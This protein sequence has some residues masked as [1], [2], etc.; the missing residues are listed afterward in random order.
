[1]T[2]P[3][4]LTGTATSMRACLDK[5]HRLDAARTPYGDRKTEKRPTGISRGPLFRVS[6]TSFCLMLHAAH[7]QGGLDAHPGMIREQQ[8]RVRQLALEALQPVL[9]RQFPHKAGDGAAL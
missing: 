3:A 1:M 2:Q 8:Q 6:W 4:P 7:A 5:F 9:Q